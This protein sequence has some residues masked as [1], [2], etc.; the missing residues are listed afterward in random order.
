MRS[1]YKVLRRMKEDRED[2]ASNP[3]LEPRIDTNPGFDFVDRVF[4]GGAMI[5]EVAR[6]SYT[7]EYLPGYHYQ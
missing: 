4:L 2:Y 1:A 7:L 6:S 5:G 3:S